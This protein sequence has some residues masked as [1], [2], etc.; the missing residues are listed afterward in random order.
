MQFLRLLA[1]YRPALR[2]HRFSRIDSRF[3]GGNL[4][5][6]VWTCFGRVIIW[7]AMLTKENNWTAVSGT[8][9]NTQGIP[10]RSS[11]ED[12]WVN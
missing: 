10:N 11:A 2:W 8:H 6:S 12:G 3:S 4:S 5:Y 1:E 9:S 7:S